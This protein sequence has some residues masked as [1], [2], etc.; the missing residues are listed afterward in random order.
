[1]E[2]GV[3]IAMLGAMALVFLFI[4]S[5]WLV[6]HTKLLTKPVKDFS[7]IEEPY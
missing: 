3:F 7:C 5:V 4:A 6:A 2:K 1:M